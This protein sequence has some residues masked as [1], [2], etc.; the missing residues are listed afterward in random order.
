MHNDRLVLGSTHLWVFQSPKESGID[1]KK[2][3]PI[4]YDYAQEEIAAKAGI[5]LDNAGSST[6][7]S[8]LKEDLV[9]KLHPSFKHDPSIS[10]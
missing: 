7:V 4:T 10:K 2:Y 9:I 1:K 8:L 3:P 6:D 5:K